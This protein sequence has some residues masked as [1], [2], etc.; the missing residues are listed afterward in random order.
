MSTLPL[1]KEMHAKGF[2]P[3]HSTKKNSATITALIDKYGA[4][5][6]LD[7]GCGKGMQYHEAKLHEDW[8]VPMPT[9]YDPAVPGIDVLPNALAVKFDG[10]ICCDV[11]EHLEPKEAAGVIFDVTI[12][13]KGFAFFS[14]ATYPAKKILPD[15][16]NAHLLIRSEDWWRGFMEATARSGPEIVLEFD[17]GGK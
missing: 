11:L 15:G 9:L 14:I 16:R 1:Y 12:R 10:V 7:F 2:F 3:G 6:L 17:H 4:Q 8:G 5:T 13:A